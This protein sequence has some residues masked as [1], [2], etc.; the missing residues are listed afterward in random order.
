MGQILS[1]IG[2]TISDPFNPKFYKK[3]FSQ[4]T[5]KNPGNVI[6]QFADPNGLLTEALFPPSPDKPNLPKPVDA[7]AAEA[8]DNERRRLSIGSGQRAASIRGAGTLSANLGKSTL[9]G[10]Y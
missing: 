9:G 2:T 5:W 1:G 10:G 4:Q 6:K 3:F 8:R 7:Q